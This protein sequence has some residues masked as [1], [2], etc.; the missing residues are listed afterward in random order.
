MFLCRDKVES[1]S[2]P[3]CKPMTKCL[4]FATGLPAAHF[5]LYTKVQEIYTL[6]QTFNGLATTQ[7][8]TVLPARK[9]SCSVTSYCSMAFS[10]DLEFAAVLLCVGQIAVLLC[11]GQ[12]ARKQ[13]CLHAPADT[14]PHCCHPAPLSGSYQLQGQDSVVAQA[15]G[16]SPASELQ[17]KGSPGALCPGPAPSSLITCVDRKAVAVSHP[18][19]AALAGTTGQ[20]WG[21]AESGVRSQVARLCC[22]GT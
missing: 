21:S 7:L 1:T 5:L 11:D 9:Y 3:K 6:L 15:T 17:M 2:W 8:S 16:G 14:Y 19:V 10:A 13:I 20:E 4:P 22:G 18:L 12:I